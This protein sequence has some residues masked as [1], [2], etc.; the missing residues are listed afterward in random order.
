MI[1]FALHADGDAPLFHRDPARGSP[2]CVCIAGGTTPP[3]LA[4]AE[5]LFG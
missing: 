5:R 3:P 4:V 2:H 1:M